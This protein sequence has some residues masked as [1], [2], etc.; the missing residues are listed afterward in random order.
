VALMTY[1]ILAICLL[2]IG[3]VAALAVTA[4]DGPSTQPYDTCIPCR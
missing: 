1:Y 4:P 3:G 2:L